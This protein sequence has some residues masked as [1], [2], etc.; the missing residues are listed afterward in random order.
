[1]NCFQKQEKIFINQKDQQNP[2]KITEIMK[3]KKGF[4]SSFLLAVFL[5]S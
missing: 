4:L 3:K 5:I 1:M 2:W